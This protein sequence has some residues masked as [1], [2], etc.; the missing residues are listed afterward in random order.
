MYRLNA[1]GTTSTALPFFSHDQHHKTDAAKWKGGGSAF[2]AP[3]QIQRLTFKQ[4]TR[5]ITTDQQSHSRRHTHATVSR[6]ISGT[7]SPRFRDYFQNPQHPDGNLGLF[8]DWK[9]ETSNFRT[10]QDFSVPV[11]TLN[12]GMPVPECRAILD[13]AQCSQ[14]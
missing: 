4:P 7:S 13:F 8:G 1:P 11:G 2:S 6:N 10:F 3:E 14:Q 12:L 5:I 9:M